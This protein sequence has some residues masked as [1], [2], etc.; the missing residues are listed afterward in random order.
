M[1]VR[2]LTL[3]GE[4]MQPAKPENAGRKRNPS[5][6]PAE[7]QSTDAGKQNTDIPPTV[8]D[9]AEVAPLPQP[10]PV[11]EVAEN[12]APIE[13]VPQEK[14]VRTEKKEGSR[15]Q[16]KRAFAG[17]PGKADIISGEWSA[18]KQ[19]YTIGETASLF[20]IATSHI[21]F[22][23]TEFGLKVRTTRKGDR[24][25]SP[26]NIEKLRTIYHLV[27]DQGF[28]IA[29]AKARMKAGNEKVEVPL[30]ENFSLK[31]ALCQLRDK[32]VFLRSQL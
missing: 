4:E 28:T 1:E 9:T 22:W 18:D 2:I 5:S 11:S 32:L 20:K 30:P 6:K 15:H 21:R 19:Y 23:T 3:F 25:Y 17:K 14:P 27:K 31:N 12:I 29:G 8:D 10:K 7:E 13:E 24:L 26:E 16:A